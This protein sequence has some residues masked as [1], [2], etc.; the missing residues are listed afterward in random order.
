MKKL[1]ICEKPSMA[2]ALAEYLA[3]KSVAPIR[4]NGYF[5]VN[6]DYIAWLKGHIMALCEP[7]DYKGE[8][9][10]NNF[11]YDE[12]PMIPSVFKKKI[13]LSYGKDASG[14]DRR[15]EDY[16]KI[17]LTLK[18]LSKN[19]DI[20]VN[21]GD[22]DAE[23]QILVDEV[24][25]ELGWQ[26]KEERIFITA[27]DDESI[28]RAL[29]NIED[30]KSPKN[31]NLSKSALCRSITDWL[32]GMNGSRKFSHDAGTNIS[33]GRVKVPILALV[34][35][36]NEEID[37]F[38][39][40]DF[41]EP[42]IT[43]QFGNELVTC[44]WKP[45]EDFALLDEESRLVDKTVADCLVKNAIGKKIQ[46]V[47]VTKKHQ[48]ESAPLPFSLAKLQE[49]ACGKLGIGLKKFDEILQSLYEEK[50]LLT[51][52][53]SDCQYIPESQ[54]D[55]AR[56]IIS[57]L[58]SLDSLK[59]IA[60][61]ADYNIK[62]KAFDSSKTTAH[63]AIIPTS[64]KVNVNNLSKIE[65][66]VYE[67]V[68]KR[69]LMQFYPEHEYDSTEMLFE[70]DGE[71]FVAIG[72][73][74][75]EVG[76]NCLVSSED[77]EKTAKDEVSNLPNLK[78]GTLGVVKEGKLIT[79]TT[80]AP[81]YFTQE[82]LIATLTNAH[83]YVHD[84]NLASVVKSIKGIGTPA[85]R[86][87]II[88]EL[89]M[90]G[91]LLEKQLGKKKKKYLFVSERASELIG[92]L[93]N[94]LTYPDQTALMELELEKVAAGTLSIDMYRQNVEEYVRQ[95][96]QVKTSFSRGVECPKCHKGY[97]KLAKD[98]T[99]WFCSRWNEEG[100]ECK[101]F[102]PDKDGHPQI[103]ACPACRL[104]FLKLS[105]DKSSWYCSRRKDVPISCFEVFLNIHGEP[106]TKK[107]DACQRGY[108][109]KSKAGRLYCS[110]FLGGCNSYYIEK[111]GYPVLVKD[112][113]CPICKI[114][115]LTKNS[116]GT[117]SCTNWRNGCKA[118]FEDVGS[119][120]YTKLCTVCGIGY[121]RK[122]KKGN[123]YCT[124]FKQCNSHYSEKNG[125]PV[126]AENVGTK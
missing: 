92:S 48:K 37:N 113:E 7:E 76:W 95:L 47:N 98:G 73:V 14:K 3:G 108:I 126:L 33:V 71:T 90:K 66:E 60:N 121:I 99:N 107:C 123:W 5:Q 13:K 35:R 68:A 38:K 64:V 85:T 42:I 109:R 89:L 23:G 4:K 74:V 9:D 88:D 118:A 61:N 87:V 12:L 54:F 34:K 82:S 86:S 50:K 20:I 63:H 56:N 59:D 57:N 44:K 69:Y 67:I 55:D 41:Y 111:K 117:W 8:W 11:S 91:L 52:P 100:A 120:P 22:A 19:V 106:Y 45:K 124:N 102:F 43:A 65:L 32:I 21:S 116:F 79:K 94:S 16:L 84:K 6:N 104:G 17:F 125:K 51:Y 1:Y 114:G 77:K 26:G 81:K 2:N 10:R 29:Y 101:T 115:T 28:K 18:A 78:N 75:T 72:K 49:Y 105:P 27:Y 58:E 15:T 83:K 39:S 53:R 103:I 40:K 119:K 25:E 70:C 62:G 30:N 110:N 31:A 96:M 97:L 80:S 36:R 112:I 46:V 24:I 93:P 122:S